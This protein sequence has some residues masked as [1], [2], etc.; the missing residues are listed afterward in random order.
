ML[1]NTV[2][3]NQLLKCRRADR[4]DAFILPR[5]LLYGTPLTNKHRSIEQ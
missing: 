5:P 4:K 2:I 3:T 1:G